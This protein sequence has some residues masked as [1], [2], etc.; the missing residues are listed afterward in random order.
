M[1]DWSEGFSSGV[2]RLLAAAEQAARA[3]EREL[4]PAD[5]LRAMLADE[6]HATE[7]L[8]AAQLTL[9][10]EP[11]S[12][13][14]PLSVGRLLRSARQLTGAGEVTSSLHL[15]LALILGDDSLATRLADHGLS[16]QTVRDQLPS[17]D[18]AVP[19]PITTDLRIAP[20][21]ASVDDLSATW[22]ILD[23]AANRA[24]EGLRV[25]EDQAR[26]GLDDA[27]PKTLK[28]IGE[29]EDFAQAA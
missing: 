14:E 4:L 26:F 9:L 27:E 22:R 13:E 7:L 16:E 19:E 1:A 17:G 21:A 11:C 23:A 29:R 20:A 6:G 10:D 24:R 15:L 28:E 25:L 3:A 18:A 5:L 8:R 12:P 2:H